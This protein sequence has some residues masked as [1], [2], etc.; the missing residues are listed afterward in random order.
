MAEMQ[1]QS[2]GAEDGFSQ[3]T[4][5][6]GRRA[7]KRQAEQLTAAGEDGDA[8]GMDAEEARPLKRPVFPPLSGDVF[9][10]L[11]GTRSRGGSS[12]WPVDDVFSREVLTSSIK[13]SFLRVICHF[14]TPPASQHLVSCGFFCLFVCFFNCRVGKKKHGKFQ[15]QLI[16]TH[17]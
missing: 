8:G 12:W 14:T 7:K 16:D 5:K 11:A 17:H 10:V 13:G 4:R 6:G 3:I 1:T 2:A 15:S 9:L